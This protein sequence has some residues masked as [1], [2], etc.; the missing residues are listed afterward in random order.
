MVRKSHALSLLQELA[1]TFKYVDF[2]N[3]EILQGEKEE[4]NYKLAVGWK[5]RRRDERKL[6]EVAAKH[7]LEIVITKE[8]NGFKT[9][10]QNKTE[11][12][13]LKNYA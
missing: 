6:L 2:S 7:G 11:T 8:N 1:S 10:F 5:P 13:T 4:T 9:I 3:H 12:N